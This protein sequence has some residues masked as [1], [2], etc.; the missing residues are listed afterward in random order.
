ML[1]KDNVVQGFYSGELHK[2]T[3]ARLS[4]YG[5]TGVMEPQ[6]AKYH[7]KIAHHLSWKFTKFR[8]REATLQ[9][10]EHL[11]S[12]RLGVAIENR[13]DVLHDVRAHI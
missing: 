11:H 1:P 12:C 9:I 4:Q 13:I 8:F 7:W 5:V 10:T 2:G 6:C 3:E